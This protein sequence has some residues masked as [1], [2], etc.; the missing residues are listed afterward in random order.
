MTPRQA[1]VRM[2]CYGASVA[3]PATIAILA[4]PIIQRQLTPLEFGQITFAWLLLGFLANADLGIGRALGRH[5]AR[6]GGGPSDGVLLAAVSSQ[7]LIGLVIGLLGLA[8]GLGGDRTNL[9]LPLLI[10]AALTVPLATIFISI[11]F[12]LD[13]SGRQA[14]AAL[15]S[16]LA[17]T[18]TYAI[19]FSLIAAGASLSISLFAL[20]AARSGL[21]LFCLATLIPLSTYGRASRSRILTGLREL[22]GFGS[23]IMVSSVFASANLYGDKLYGARGLSLAALSMYAVPFD[24]LS[25]IT[26]LPAIVVRVLSPIYDAQDFRPVPM[27][28]QRLGVGLSLLGWGACIIAVPFATPLFEHLLSD[29]DPAEIAFIVK[30][31]LIGISVTPL[32]Y[33]AA[34]YLTTCGHPHVP[35]IAQGVLLAPY[36][37]AVYWAVTHGSVRWLVV[38]W[39]ARMLVETVVV[40]AASIRLTRYRLASFLTGVGGLTS[41]VFFTGWVL[42][43]RAS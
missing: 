17:N 3:V 33:M 40:A 8:F 30:A 39:S 1:M 5:I 37:I 21:F 35:T 23:W 19:P 22:T 24:L 9:P 34:M 41:L 15:L 10:I 12:K 14:Y 4:L 29:S 32:A 6:N 18:M 7:V 11:R 2:A 13:A 20:I 26:I 25:K 43:E 27:N 31:L 38:A 28:I 36:A 42:L 16:G